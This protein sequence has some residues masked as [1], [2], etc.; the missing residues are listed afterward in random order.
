MKALALGYGVVCYAIFFLTFLYAIGFLG[1]FA[2]PRSVD[3]GGIQSPTG[4]AI[5]VNVLLLGVF[6]LQHSVMARREFKNVWTKLV[7]APVERST[8]VLLSSLAMILLFW[9]WR[10]MPAL[11]WNVQNGV[12]QAILWSVFAIGWVLV[13]L[14]T[15]LINHFELFGL[16]QVW[17]HFKG[18]G[19][20]QGEFK[21]PF[22]Y[23]F[24][25]HPLY[26]GWFTTFWATPTMSV[27][28][29]L[30]AFVSS[31]Y[32]LVAVQIEERDLIR[33]HPEY[34]DYRRRVPMLIPRLA[35]R[36]K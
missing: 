18:L 34:A 35:R 4:V 7:P 14:A 23:K 31:A 10:P 1:N 16:S 24:V 2:V 25:R 30:F 8:Y 11:I 6:G 26:V 32:I 12:G 20:P 5:L 27:G 22:L 28:H 29:F 17:R 19:A 21:E 9:Q 36:A 15:F 13:L 3:A 33:M